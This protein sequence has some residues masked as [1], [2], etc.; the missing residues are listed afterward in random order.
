MGNVCK[1]HARGRPR[2]IGKTL[3]AAALA[4]ALSPGSA[5]PANDAEVVSLVGRGEARRDTAQDWRAAVIRERLEGGSFVRTGDF[6]QMALL[7]HDQTQLRLNQNSMVQLRQIGA[8]ATPTTLELKVG[9]VWAQAK[10]RTPGSSEAAPAVTVHTPN[11]VAAIRGTDWDLAVDEDGSATLT[12]LSGEV[13]FFNDLGSVRVLPNEQ[14]TVRPGQAPVKR[15][16]TD[17]RERVQ[18]VT[19]WRPAPRRWAGDRATTLAAGIEAIESGRYGDALVRLAGRPEPEAAMLR[20]DVELSLG[21]VA[22]AIETLRPHAAHPR[23]AAL[24][25]RAWIIADRADEAA[26]S[27]AATD[28]PDV[29]HD[30]AKGELA[31]FEGEASMARAAFEQAI[32]RAPEAAEAW[33]GLGRVDADR[34][35]IGPARHALGRAMELDPG[36]SH[37]PAELATLETMANALPRAQALFEATLE[38]QPDDYVALTGLGI[39][40]L[41]RGDA[42][43]ALESF[44]KAGVIEP[45]Y[46]R[47]AMWQGVAYYQLGNRLRAEEM[48]RRAAELDAKD[49]LPHMMLSLIASDQLDFGG[50][51]LDAQAAAERMPYL[52]SLNQL[53]NNQKG[54]ANVG[55]A[56]AQFGLEEW[57]HAYAYD[58][59]T[60]YW[61]GSHLFLA[62]RYSGNFLKNSELFKG[63]LTDPSVFGASNRYSTLVATP[64]HHASFGAN[65]LDLGYRVKGGT[66]TLNGYDVDL[67]PFSYFIQGDDA[68]ARPGD[69]DLSINA[70]NYTAGLGFKPTHA[71]NAFLFGTRTRAETLEPFLAGQTLIFDLD[72][73]SA[74]SDAGLNLRFGPRSQSWIKAGRGDNRIQANLLSY[75]P[76]MAQTL[77]EL[78]GAQITPFF[79]ILPY[80]EEVEQEDGQFRHTIDFRPGFQATFGAEYGKQEQAFLAGLFLVSDNASVVLPYAYATELRSQEAYL[81]TRIQPND[82]WLFDLTLARQQLREEFRS[83]ILVASA[84]GIEGSNFIIEKRRLDEWNPRAGFVWRPDDTHTLRVAAQRW[85]RPA[86]VASLAPVDT[87]G[88]PL[89]DRIVGIGGLLKRARIQYEWQPSRSTHLVVYADHREANNRP[90]PN[91][92]KLVSDIDLSTLDALRNRQR[93]TTQAID[94]WE[95]TPKFSEGRIATAGLALNQILSRELSGALRVQLNNGRN[96]SETYRD[97]RIPYLPR[98]LANL[99][100]TW[101]PAARWQLR[102]GATWRSPRYTDEENTMRLASGW[103]F[104][105]GAYWESADKRWTVEAVVENLYANKKASAGH[106]PVGGVQANLRF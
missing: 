47:A 44:L 13:E 50:A 100:L 30:L 49:P 46:A 89:D 97:A 81:S 9:R 14:A 92:P 18:W 59:Y 21:Q 32:A 62:D 53:L 70:R 7:L 41:K 106:S 27:L 42:E 26:K 80:S 15:L 4:A 73:K 54:N 99:Q 103:G 95:D 34:E 87:A 93:L 35:D 45:R 52:K 101:Q 22:Q 105:L 77:S 63:F 60:P 64:G 43:A 68:R 90:T 75:S 66:V 17:A 84:R 5:L 56:L 11:A 72:L 16:L 19:A 1:R 67:L 10:R 8:D 25:A 78:T 39:L 3:L 61:A 2:R 82:Q 76:A 85:R 55:S 98:A 51:V 38:A 29:E 65:A 48:L 94:F 104:G 91:N 12:V 88:I 86:S 102:A 79:P 40:Q 58:A 24:L 57:A 36:A 83:L 69:I 96:R 28:V 33:S 23:A 74:R 6:S 71:L 20:A 37:H 31:R